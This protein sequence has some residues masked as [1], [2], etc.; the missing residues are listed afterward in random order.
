MAEQAPP[1]EVLPLFPLAGVLLLPG[2]HIPLH[3]F[4]PRYRNMVHDALQNEA[5]IGLIQPLAPAAEEEMDLQAEPDGENPELYTVGCAGMIEHWEGL[6]DGRYVMLIKGVRRFRSVRELPVQRGYRR[7]EVDY[8]EFATDT[9]DEL[10][11][12]IDSARLMAALRTFADAHQI[13]LEL[14]RLGQ[15][16]GRALLNSMAMALPFAPAEKQALLEAV[17]LRERFDILIALMDM[18][19]ELRPNEEYAPPTLN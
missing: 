10:A 19:I 1:P 12:D 9:L 7:V 11:N 13:T 8:Q 2:A 3:V 14:D 5:Y 16:P 4:E 17:S 6:A 15:L 18:G